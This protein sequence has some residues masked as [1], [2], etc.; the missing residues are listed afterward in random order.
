MISYGLDMDMIW[1]NS[2]YTDDIKLSQK[3]RSEASSH[4][5]KPFSIVLVYKTIYVRLKFQDPAV[6]L[7][8]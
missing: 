5:V 2:L 3:C 1:D 4:S 7:T 8:L 6:M